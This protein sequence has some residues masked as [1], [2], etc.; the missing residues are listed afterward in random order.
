MYI[1]HFLGEDI[2]AIYKHMHKTLRYCTALCTIKR[3]RRIFCHMI[4][5]CDGDQP[6]EE[7]EQVSLGR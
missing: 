1:G 6:P 4:T 5:N 7:V 2:T 3:W